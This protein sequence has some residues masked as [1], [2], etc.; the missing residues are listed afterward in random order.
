MDSGLF[1]LAR[2]LRR[3][4]QARLWSPKA[5]LFRTGRPYCMKKAP[6]PTLQSMIWPL[7][8]PSVSLAP[9]LDH[10]VEKGNRVRLVELR[11]IIRALRKRRRYKQALE[12][13]LFN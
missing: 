5:F 4:F 2:G 8:H 3:V 10:W 12:V 7:G 9:E 6:R 1:S 11:N 13:H